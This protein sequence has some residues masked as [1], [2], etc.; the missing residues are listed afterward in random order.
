MTAIL[1]LKGNGARLLNV[2]S[3]VRFT[4]VFPTPRA[5]SVIVARGRGRVPLM[6]DLFFTHWDLQ[7]RT[8]PLIYTHVAQITF[9]PQLPPRR[10]PLAHWKAFNSTQLFRTP[11]ARSQFMNFTIQPLMITPTKDHQCRQMDMA[12]LLTRRFDSMRSPVR[13]RPLEMLGPSTPPA[14]VWTAGATPC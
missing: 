1:V 8:P 2:K 11:Q 7:S 9:I 12:L 10:H 6:K 3:T 4:G 14:S 13:M 5:R